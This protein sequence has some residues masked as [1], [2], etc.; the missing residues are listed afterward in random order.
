MEKIAIAVDGK[1]VSDH[2]GRC[3]SFVLIDLDNQKVVHKEELVNP[4]HR[5]GFL[6]EFLAQRGVQ[7]IICGGMGRRAIDLFA[8]KG[9][10]PIVGITGEMNKV[11]DQYIQGQLKEGDSHCQPGAGKGYG[12]EKE[13]H[14]KSSH[15]DREVK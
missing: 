10:K 12:I 5:T 1:V 6:P 8:A 11:V 13:D 9:I 14:H 7:T 4:G 2:F 3:P 15:F